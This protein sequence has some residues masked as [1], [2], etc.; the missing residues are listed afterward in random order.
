LKQPFPKENNHKGF[1]NTTLEFDKKN[2]DVFLSI[3][4][5]QQDF[6][7]N[8]IDENFK[9]DFLEVETKENTKVESESF[10]SILNNRQEVKLDN[11]NL[12][13]IKT[14]SFLERNKRKILICVLILIL[15]LVFIKL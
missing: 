15:S 5:I 3:P 10:N 8:S 13:S 2:E 12:T 1:S 4:N 14:E 6:L 7:E 11:H 9:K